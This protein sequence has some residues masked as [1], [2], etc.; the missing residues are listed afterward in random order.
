MLGH[1]AGPYRGF[2]LKHGRLGSVLV[3]YAD[4][5]GYRWI[6]P[7]NLVPIPVPA[8]ETKKSSVDFDW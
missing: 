3:Q 8:D 4:G 2:Q 7:Q 6:S 5:S 1:R